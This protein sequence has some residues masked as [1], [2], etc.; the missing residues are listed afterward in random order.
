MS[1]GPSPTRRLDQ[2]YGLVGT[3][4][5]TLQIFDDHASARAD[6]RQSNRATRS[7]ANRGR[8]GSHDR[9]SEHI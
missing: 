9:A 7:A 3:G 6:K 2:R 4:L 5:L 8:D 1:E